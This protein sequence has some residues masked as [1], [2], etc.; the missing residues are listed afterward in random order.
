MMTDPREELERLI[1][2]CLD[3]EASS[4]ERRS[5]ERTMRQDPQADALFEE[6]A[7]LDREA[8]QAI[9]SAV[10]GTSISL[11]PRSGMWREVGLALAACVAML[12]WIHPP[13]QPTDGTERADASRASW[14][15][16][17]P[18]TTDTRAAHASG[19]ERLGVPLADTDREWIVVPSREPGKYMVIE[20]KRTRT[21]LI[22]LRR[23][24]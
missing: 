2:R 19:Y 15:A 4:D 11:A 8:A 17:P 10:G 12:L 14:F 7:A 6:Y 3:G 24:Y 23:D 16:P 21:R 22:P 1:S 18:T 9:R 20:V 13:T 5:L